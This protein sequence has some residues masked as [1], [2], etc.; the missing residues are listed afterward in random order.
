M[1]RRRAIILALAGT[2]TACASAPPQRPAP[3]APAPAP[4][5]TPA[6]PPAQSTPPAVREVT[7]TPEPAPI[8]VP[9]TLLGLAPADL[10]S[11]LGAPNLVRRDGPAEIRLYGDASS[12]C[13]LHVFLYENSAG[14]RTVDYF[15][16]RQN[17]RRLTDDD[18]NGCL[19][20]LAKPPS[21][22]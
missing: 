17:S 19:R 13:T 7:R 5:M 9:P 8:V 18:V 15:E 22:S 20:A 4:T 21:T 1:R 12:F 2:L 10:D 3:T 6:P 11:F 16:A 14:G